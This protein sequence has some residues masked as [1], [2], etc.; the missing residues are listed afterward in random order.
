VLFGDVNPSG[1][2]P[3]SYP[4]QLADSPAPAE[5]AEVVYPG[6]AGKVEY[7]EGM[8]VGYRWFDAKKI[9]PLFPF[10]FGLSYTSFALSNLNVVPVVTGNLQTVTVSVAVNNTGSREGAEVVQVYV[11][12]NNPSVPR[13]P[14]ELK[15]FAKI[16]L[17]AGEKGTVAATL[18]AMA[19]AHYDPQKHAWVADA[20]DYTIYVGDSAGNLPLK[21]TLNLPA[22]MTMKEGP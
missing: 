6:Q 5:G 11:G 15:G 21:A 7:R 1:H 19:F 13:P 4:R 18:D 2:L 3:C 10:G 17:K 22:A 16:A 14:K 9:E 8:L 12:Q 20:G